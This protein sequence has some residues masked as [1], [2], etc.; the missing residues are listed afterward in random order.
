MRIDRP[1]LI[2]ELMPNYSLR[3]VDHV[4]V[5]AEPPQAYA[6]ARNVEMYRVPFVRRLFWLRT[7]PERIAH[8]LRGKSQE[9]NRSSRID[10]ITGAGS[11]FLLLGERPDREVVVGSVGKFWQPTI[12]FVPV[13][14]AEFRTFERPGYGK[15]AWCIRV[16]PRIG[17]GSWITIELRVGATDVMS[18]SRF[19]RYW[20]LIGRFSHAI[21]HGVLRLLVQELGA[22]PADASRELAGDVLLP[23]VRFQKTH[24]TTIE[25]PDD[26]VWPW[27]MQ[28]GAGR[29]GWYSF[30]FLDNGR[31]PSADHIIPE[32]QSL[33]VGDILPALPRRTDG[34]AVVSLDA[35]RSLVLGDPALVPGG[36]RPKSAPPWKT[37]WAFVL[38][39]I[40]GDATRLT[41][42]VRADYAPG[43][44]MAVLRP[45]IALAHEVMER[46]QLH[47]LRLRAEAMGAT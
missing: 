44:K 34:F 11:G 7:L 19:R 10:D 21:R 36:L 42:R 6:V 22:V 27:L 20:W 3:Q 14:P 47:N 9:L 13:T 26:H 15:L 38:E 23:G 8:W 29:A 40:G 1:S 24:A 45:A 4:A 31:M 5:A 18:L 33:S 16:D 41:V 25:A 43:L 32:L 46:R 17:G 28:M 12:E 37:S 35:P 30:D 2:T 39:P